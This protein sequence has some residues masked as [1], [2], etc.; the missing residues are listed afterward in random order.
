MSPLAEA[1]SANLSTKIRL[2]DVAAEV[3]L[4]L[5]FANASLDMVRQ[6]A[7]VSNGSLYHHYPTKTHLADALYAHILRDYHTQMMGTLT[8]N[9]RAEDGVKRL[10]SATMQWVVNNPHRARLLHDLRM[11]GALVGGPRE[12]DETNAKAFGALAEWVAARTAA[13]EMREMPQPV[14]TALVFSPVMALM[15]HWASQPK[16]KVNPKVRAA[17]EHAAWMAVAA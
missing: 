2:L 5:G 12:R 17:L 11:I 10:I 16:P 8:D 7:G 3:F 1:P 14:W 4:E 6:R 15:P 13:G 9:P